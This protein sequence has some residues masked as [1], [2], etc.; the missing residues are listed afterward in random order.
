MTTVALG[1]TFEV[2]HKGH[3]A[4]L[5]RAFGEGDEVLIGLTTDEMANAARDRT[6]RPY[7]EREA[8][9]RA[10]ISE[11]HPGRGFSIVPLSDRHGPAAHREDIEVL[12]VSVFTH[13]TGVE[14]NEARRARG[15][16]ELRLARIDHVLADDGLPISSSRILAGECDE[17]GRV[18]GR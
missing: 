3:R 18:P 16:P 17:E 1:G 2:L 14:I 5:A 15:L 10:Y 8:A 11:A 12:V 7:H 9:L 4:L 13:G 6:V